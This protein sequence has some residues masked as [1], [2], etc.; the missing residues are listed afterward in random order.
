MLYAANLQPIVNCDT[1]ASGEPDADAP[2]PLAAVRFGYADVNS[3]KML[4]LVEIA[5][6]GTMSLTLRPVLQWIEDGQQANDSGEYPRTQW[7]MIGSEITF[8]GTASSDN[9]FRD[10]KEIDIPG[11][12]SI[13]FRLTAISGTDAVARVRGARGMHT[14]F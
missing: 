10:A 13:G 1:T 3:D 7:D 8:T 9:P 2:T 5:G 12:V 11:G 6:S 4:L 14:R